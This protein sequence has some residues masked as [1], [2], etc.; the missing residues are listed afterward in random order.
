[1]YTSDFNINITTKNVYKY[2]QIVNF[3]YFAEKILTDDLDGI[4][5]NRGTD[6]IIIERK[7]LRT[8]MRNLKCHI[9]QDY[10]GYIFPVGDGNNDFIIEEFKSIIIIFLIIVV[11]HTVFFIV[12]SYFVAG[13]PFIALKN[14]YNIF[15]NVR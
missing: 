1:M 13:D 15:Y 2:S 11:T 3:Q 10:S 9:L 5:L 12:Y 8:Y 4:I 6:N 14:F 7:F